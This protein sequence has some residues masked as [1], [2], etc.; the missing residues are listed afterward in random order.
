[1]NHIVSEVVANHIDVNHKF[2]F[3][4]NDYPVNHK[5]EKMVEKH[6]AE[7][8]IFAKSFGY[9][10]IKETIHSVHHVFR[11]QIKNTKNLISY[12][13]LHDV[14]KGDKST[15]A[16]TI[17]FNDE[18][19]EYNNIKD[20]YRQFK[21]LVESNKSVETTNTVSVDPTISQSITQP[22]ADK[23]ASGRDSNNKQQIFASQFNAL[24]QPAEANGYSIKQY[25]AN[26]LVIYFKNADTKATILYEIAIKTDKYTVIYT[27][28]GGDQI[29]KTF[30]KIFQA[31]TYV[32]ALLTRTKAKGDK[33]IKQPL[34]KDV[35]DEIKDVDRFDKL[36]D[37]IVA[38]KQSN[39]K[40]YTRLI[41]F[42]TTELYKN[43]DIKNIIDLD[44]NGDMGQIKNII[45]N[46]FTKK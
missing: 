21:S 40:G 32:S 15:G 4:L 37:T 24:K 43:K 13:I 30:K 6:F 25:T 26:Q 39:D 9:K 34:A 44:Y 17:L 20:A 12:D 11:L 36:F 28:D 22:S 38:Y 2:R 27:P 14:K 42:L 18:K 5:L 41:N 16:Y 19:F 33:T 3:A 46:H 29:T 10:K 35:K 23:I 8:M 45:N 7:A 31:Y 1:M